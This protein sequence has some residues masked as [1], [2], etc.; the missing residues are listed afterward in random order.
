[1]YMDRMKW[2]KQATAEVEE[3]RERRQG[4]GGSRRS[5]R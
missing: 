4:S 2:V 3:G 5:G 1:M